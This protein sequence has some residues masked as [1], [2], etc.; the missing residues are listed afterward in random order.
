MNAVKATRVRIHENGSLY[1][2]KCSGN[3]TNHSCN[4]QRIKI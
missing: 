2:T 3:T 1:I 4:F